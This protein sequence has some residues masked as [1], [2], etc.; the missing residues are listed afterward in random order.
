MQRVTA[1]ESV[2]KRDRAIVAAGLVGVAGLA[3]AYMV[4]LAWDMRGMDM[5][6]MA[7]SQRGSWDSVDLGSMYLMWAVMMVPTAAPMILVFAA[8]NRRR[9]DNDRPFVPT[10]IFLAGYLVVWFGFALLA[11][12]VQWGLHE[13]ELM[14]SMMGA[15]SPVL[16]GGL[17]LTAG[18]FQWTPFK[19]A[20]L[21]RCRTPIG[22]IMSEWREGTRGTLNMGIRHGIY[23]LGCCWFL[24]GL[25]FVAGVM[26]LLWMAAIAGYMLVEKVVPSGVSGNWV[27]WGAGVLLVGWGVWIIAGAVL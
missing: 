3:W 25:M 27:N 21:N 7:M 12:L 9:R 14:S 10:G 4:Y 13:A 16:G 26:N 5:A 17:L 19:S 15:V 8:V 23:C 1:L 2:L 22:F 24:M 6:G 11:T 18:V 20:C